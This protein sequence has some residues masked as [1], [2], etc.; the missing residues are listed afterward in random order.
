M[1]CT[2][3]GQDF[4]RIVLGV[5]LWLVPAAGFA[6]N[7][8]LASILPE[9]LGNTITLLPSNLPD[10]PNHIAHFKPG[11]DQLVVPT[12]VN[13]ALLTLLSTYPIGTPSG[14]FTYTFDPALGT[15]TRTSE[16]F[17]PSFAQR[18]LTAGRGKVSVGF[19]TSTRLMT[20]SRA[21]ICGSAGRVASR[22]T[23]PTPT[24]ARPD[25]PGVDARRFADDAA[26]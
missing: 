22:S 2:R 25:R 24:A 10:Q 9:L 5:A 19:G 21:S 8:P 18:A 1:F 7:A 13:Q 6:Q 3:S 23:F 4:I 11:P 17:G 20:C 12:Q 14:G 16:S 15:L 26:V